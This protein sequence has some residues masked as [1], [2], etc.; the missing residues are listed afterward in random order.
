MGWKVAPVDALAQVKA[1]ASRRTSVNPTIKSDTPGVPDSDNWCSHK[2]FVQV[3]G[4]LACPSVPVAV[5]RCWTV[6]P[7]PGPMIMVLGRAVVA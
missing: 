5:G 1:G 3:S 6:R 7:H 4:Q 2:Q